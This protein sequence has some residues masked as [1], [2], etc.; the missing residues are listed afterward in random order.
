MKFI[1]A[2]TLAFLFAL[3]AFSLY[4]GSFNTRISKKCKK[5]SSGVQR[6]ENTP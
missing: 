1:V 5:P 4:I 6:T 3:S 2:H